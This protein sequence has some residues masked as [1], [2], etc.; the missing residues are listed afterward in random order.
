[1]HVLDGSLV[2]RGA[3][4]GIIGNDARVMHVH[5]DR[6]VDVTG[7]D[8]HEMNAL[9]WVDA[10][11]R[12]KSD[13]GPVLLVMRHYAYHGVQRTMHSSGQMEAYGL[14]VN[15]R[16]MRIQGGWQVIKT[17]EGPLLLID[18]IAG[19]PHL[20]MSAPSDQDLKLR[21][22]HLT[23]GHPWDPTVLDNVL[24][25]QPDWPNIVADIGEE[26]CDGPFDEHGECKHRENPFPAKLD[27]GQDSD[28]DGA[29]DAFFTRIEASSVDTR[30][31]FHAASNLKQ[32]ILH[33]A[34]ALTRAQKRG[35]PT[36]PPLPK[37]KARDKATVTSDVDAPLPTPGP[38]DAQGTFA[39]DASKPLDTTGSTAPEPVSAT[40][41]S[42]KAS[43]PDYEAMRPHFLQVPVEKVRKTFENTTQYGVGITSNRG[44]QHIIKSPFPAHNV[45]RR[46]E[47]VASDT[48]FAETPA[49][50]GGQE[51]AQFYCGRRSLVID[52]FGM[53]SSKEFVNTLLDIIKRKGAMDKLITDGASVQASKRVTDVS[54]HL[55]I[56]HW[57]SEPHCQW[58]NYAKR[59]YQNFKH[60]MEWHSRWRNIPGYAWLL[61]AQWVAD[62]MNLTAECSRGYRTPLEALE[63]QTQDI[64]ILLMF[65]FW[66]K[67]T[68]KRHKDKDYSG[69]I[70]SDKYH[71]ISG[72]FVG[73]AHSVGHALT[74]KV[75]TDDTLHVVPRSQ[76]LLAK[77]DENNIKA[78]LPLPNGKPIVTYKRGPKTGEKEDSFVLPTIND[79]AQPFENDLPTPKEFVRFKEENSEAKPSESTDE[80]RGALVAEQSPLE[81][82]PSMQEKGESDP[83]NTDPN[84]DSNPPITINRGS[85]QKKVKVETVSK[86]EEEDRKNYWSPMESGPL[87]DEPE[88]EWVDTDEDL[89]PHLRKREEGESFDATKEG[90]FT[91]PNPTERVDPD[92]MVDRTMLM[93]PQPDGTRLR[94]RTDH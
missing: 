47:P 30:T 43:S 11:S 27:R 75:L 59:Q 29:L 3:N 44:I 77:D 13:V 60:N 70:G 35:D 7:I 91:N 1:M 10:V 71:E 36:A 34:N 12:C 50:F 48:I 15:D 41:K 24:S 42:T 81:A 68:I 19:L 83:T 94:A 62:V 55:I 80:Q 73:F 6:N 63:G 52:I 54:R 76:L 40:P 85:G 38:T 56:E 5:K 88:V 8:N 49:I 67:V 90:L 25:D 33:D 22:V 46:N 72:R 82:F 18:I 61:L 89:A 28:D 4:G 17:V 53:R 2:D 31:A 86:E 92:K 20:K 78:E 39:L 66:D 32:P 9:K 23:S 45:P 65:L 79:F 69:M 21:Q 87:R 37:R 74:F 26:L 64:S 14:R 57:Q 58:Q 51:M 16:S 93:P 84:G